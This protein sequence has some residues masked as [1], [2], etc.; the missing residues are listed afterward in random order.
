MDENDVPVTVLLRRNHCKNPNFVLRQILIT[1]VDQVRH[2]FRENV[3]KYT[4]TLF[5]DKI[6][7]GK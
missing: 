3:D 5:P 6:L 7:V 1:T 2:L 4:P